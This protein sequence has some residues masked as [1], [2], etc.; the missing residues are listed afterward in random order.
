MRDARCV[1]VLATRI[2]EGIC[3][4]HG[5]YNEEGKTIGPYSWYGYP[6]LNWSFSWIAVQVGKMLEDNGYRA[7]PIPPQ[8]YQYRHPG[9]GL[10]DFY[11]K[12]AAVAA[13]LGE[14]GL[15]RLFLSPQYGAHQRLLSIITN[16]PLEPDPMYNGPQLC[17]RKECGDACVKV[18]PL[19]AFGDKLVSVKI[20]DKVYEHLE[21]D[22]KACTWNA[23]AGKYLRGNDELPRYPT[24]QEI[25]KLLKEAGGRAKLQ[26][27]MNP[28]DASLQQFARSPTCGAC[29]VRCRAPWT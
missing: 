18:C 21:L 6:V 10:P 24:R 16:A 1:V 19:K 12:H 23:I 8:G 4:V 3:D 26:S 17:N 5:A 27:K 29:L 9:T 28:M 25:D 2:L 13:G 22:M 7:I 20:G 15:N 11:H 14:L